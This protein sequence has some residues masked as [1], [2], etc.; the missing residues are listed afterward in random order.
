[1]AGRITLKPL[2]GFDRSFS[3]WLGRILFKESRASITLSG[4]MTGGQ[5]RHQSETKAFQSGP[6]PEGKFGIDVMRIIP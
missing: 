1:M 6:S 3:K 5:P 4:E 2:P